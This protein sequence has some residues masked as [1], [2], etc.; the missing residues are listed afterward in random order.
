ML[1]VDEPSTNLLPI[2]P[3]RREEETAPMTDL[4]GTKVTEAGAKELE[5]A[6]PECRVSR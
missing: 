5:K 1:T 2:A 3:P 6:L 4:T